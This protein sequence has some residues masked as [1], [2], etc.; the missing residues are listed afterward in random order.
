MQPKLKIH[1]KFDLWFLVLMT[2][3][4]WSLAYQFIGQAIDII[5]VGLVN[6]ANLSNVTLWVRFLATGLGVYG[7]VWVFR[8]YI[9]NIKDRTLREFT[10]KQAISE[11]LWGE[12]Y[13]TDPKA[14]KYNF[15]KSQC[16]KQTEQIISI[17]REK[18]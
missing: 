6:I 18:E 17:L 15:D 12:F 1:P 4:L 14:P 9:R 8:I 7:S 5:G 16:D 11:F 10:Q 3:I 13:K 2:I